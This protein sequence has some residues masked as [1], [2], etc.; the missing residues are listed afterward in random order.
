MN[1]SEIVPGRSYKHI[2]QSIDRVVRRD[3][4]A[5][6]TEETTGP[7]G[8][9][10]RPE[11]KEHRWAPEIFADYHTP[12]GVVHDVRIGGL[13]FEGLHLFRPFEALDMSYLLSM[14]PRPRPRPIIPPPIMFKIDLGPKETETEKRVREAIEAIAINPSGVGLTH[15]KILRDEIVRLRSELAKSKQETSRLNGVERKSSRAGL[16]SCDRRLIVRQAED[17]MSISIVLLIILFACAYVHDTAPRKEE[18]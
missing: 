7:G 4:D 5:I 17:A 3:G 18:T 6:I 12:L 2:D 16:D 14:E 8:T 11:W 13:P 15:A 10:P 9:S 1:T